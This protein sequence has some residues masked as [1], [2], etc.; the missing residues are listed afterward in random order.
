[1]ENRVLIVPTTGEIYT[2]WSVMEFDL[3]MTPPWQT[4]KKSIVLLEI[5]Q[6][7]IDAGTYCLILSFSGGREVIAFKV[8]YFLISMTKYM[9]LDKL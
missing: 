7:I 3:K 6:R 5:S 8:T 1:M 9:T 4:Q 2:L